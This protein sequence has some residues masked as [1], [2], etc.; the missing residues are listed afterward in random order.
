[1]LSL[2]ARKKTLGFK[3]LINTEN[4]L[5]EQITVIYGLC[6]TTK[7]TDFFAFLLTSP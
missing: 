7:C 2:V 3:R 4:S 1:M 6:L 5:G